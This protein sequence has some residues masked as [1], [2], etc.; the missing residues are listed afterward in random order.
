MRVLCTTLPACGHFFPLVPLSRAL[1]DRG[2][3]VR[4][5]TAAEF[6]TDV[7]AAE[8]TPVP[9]GWCLKKLRS[10]LERR[11]VGE[12]V[13][14]SPGRAAARMFSEIAP[15]A[16]LTDLL[17]IAAGWRPEVILHE[18]GE[19]A[20]PLLAALVGVPNVCVTWPAPSR[21]LADLERLERAL[22]PLWDSY[23]LPVSRFGGLFNHLHLDCCPVSLQVDAPWS[24]DRLALRPGLYAGVAKDCDNG[25]TRG[26][27]DR[28]TVYVTLGTV[29][30]YNGA[31]ET[32]QAV[33]QAIDRA[34][35]QAVV[36]CG[37]SND[38]SVCGAVRKSITVRQYVPQ[39]AV[40]PHCIAV[41]CHGGAGTTM[42]ALA[43][44]LPVLVLPQ[45]AASQ[46]RMAEACKLSGA[47]RVLAPA[48]VSSD[49][50]LRELG[51]LLT[52]PGFRAA[53][54]A[55]R[56]EIRDM[57]EASAGA[58]AIEALIAKR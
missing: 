5:A 17:S 51:E 45:G 35:F 9:A 26:L 6:H 40:L 52:R 13:R 4:V 53:A 44:G 27:G 30:N 2:H 33:I 22:T 54:T 29:A 37:E 56:A 38:A 47:G 23:A 48:D 25:W 49:S 7:R 28:D 16:M 57:P 50:V 15:R 11:L 24:I 14:L 19:Y 1:M 58:Q 18:E 8:L 32:F 42:G 55:I 3:T 10:E 43:H 31:S 41:V 39:S 46:Q 21:P 20:A 34:G 36:T 12:D